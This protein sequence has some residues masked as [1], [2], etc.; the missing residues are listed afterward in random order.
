MPRPPWPRWRSTGTATRR[1]P[2]A[3]RHSSVHQ[4]LATLLGSRFRIGLVAALH[5]LVACG[6][7]APLS[8]DALRNEGYA[9]LDEGDLAAAL[10]RANPGLSDSEG[11]PIARW[12][13]RVLRAEIHAKRREMAQAL[14]LLKDPP[15][16]GT[17]DRGRAR[18]LMTAA[19]A[20]CWR[21][22]ATGAP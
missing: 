10:Q 15:P 8:P 12:L 1:S 21:A 18:A 14:D 22:A 2:Q 4:P 9:L 13:F 20:G 5:A 6:P 19:F 17:P 11:D 3:S 7:S 16:P